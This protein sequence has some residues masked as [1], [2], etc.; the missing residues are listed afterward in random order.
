M[1]I[2]LLFIFWSLWFLNF[3]TRTVLSPLLPLVEEELAITH[4]L[5]GSLFFYMSV[6]F[7]ISV[8]MS[9]WISKYLGYKRSIIVSFLTLALAL[10]GFRFAETYYYFA[11]VSF[12]VG[13]T[14]GIYFPCAIPLITSIF[15]RKNWGKAIG[16][17]ETAASASFLAIP[18]LVALALRFCHWKTCFIMFSGVCLLVIIFFWVLAPDPRPQEERRSSYSTA[19]QRVASHSQ[20]FPRTQDIPNRPYYRHYSDNHG[21]IRTERPHRRPGRP[22]RGNHA[23]GVGPCRRRLPG[24]NFCRK[25]ARHGQL[26]RR[27]EKH[28]P[29]PGPHGRQ[30]DTDSRGASAAP[31]RPGRGFRRR[32]TRHASLSPLPGRTSPL[33]LRFPPLSEAVAWSRYLC[34]VHQSRKMFLD[35]LY[36]EF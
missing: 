25:D 6:G 36:I 26:D 5:A 32:H 28:D 27:A 4:A 3:S 12:F 21:D 11:A 30:V 7:T 18:I 8:F 13:L 10:V 1:K 14:S 20:G 22:I 9:G 19:P 17:H 24:D 31:R 16:F 33:A 34:A 35:I 29:L 23:D 2:M 15:S